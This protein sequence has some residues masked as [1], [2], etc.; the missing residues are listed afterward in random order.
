MLLCGK[1]GTVGVGRVA[2]AALVCSNPTGD[3]TKREGRVS[4]TTMRARALGAAA[5]VMATAALGACASGEATSGDPG[6]RSLPVGQSC[7]SIRQELNRLDSRGVPA[8]V[9]AA[10]SGRKLSS[11]DRS[12]VDRYNGL[13]NSYLGARCHV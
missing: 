5:V 9:E 8:K 6:P 10:Q 7:Q 13:L 1:H 12:D 3:A 4:E 11:G 2:I